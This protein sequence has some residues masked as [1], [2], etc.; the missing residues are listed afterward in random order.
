MS[1]PV[2][3]VHSDQLDQSL[4]LKLQQCKHCGKV[5][6]L[7]FHG[8]TYGQSD[9]KKSIT[10]GRRVFCSNRN[11][12]SGCGRTLYLLFY[13][14]IRGGFISAELFWQFLNAILTELS[15]NKSYETID[16]SCPLSIS[17]FY[18]LWQRFK[19]STPQIRTFLA[20][21]YPHVPLS[22]NCPHRE[23]ILHL[24]V[25]FKNTA[26]NPIAEYQL[27]SQKSFI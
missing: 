12:R 5:G 8:Y 4:N 18:R 17:T 22:E 3:I 11:R 7:I 20:D 1:T 16:P 21:N 6:M 13:N 27:A 2:F 10:K 14:F 15:I 23:T 25:V 26:C 19:F 9:Y 24:S